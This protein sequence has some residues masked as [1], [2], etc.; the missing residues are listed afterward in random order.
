MGQKLHVTIGK[1][2]YAKRKT[3]GHQQATNATRMRVYTTKFSKDSAANP[4]TVM[5]SR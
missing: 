5:L 1:K 3:C 2:I 4:E